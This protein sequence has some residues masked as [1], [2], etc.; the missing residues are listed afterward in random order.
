[1]RGIGHKV[2]TH[3]FEAHLARDIAHQQELLAIA[4]WDDL[5]GEVAVFAGSR[6]DDNGVRIVLHSEVAGELGLA[7][8]VLDPQPQVGGP[9]Q[10]EK[11]ASHPVEPDDLALSVQDDHAVGKR[12]G[13][14]LQLA[15]ELHEAL[16]VEALATMQTNDLRDDL[17]PD[18]AGVGRVRVATMPQPPLE[19]EEINE[20]QGEVNDESAGESGPRTAE[21][22]PDPEP[23]N[24]RSKQPPRSEPPRLC[25]RLHAKSDPPYA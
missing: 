21:H 17:A 7:Q 23:E 11:A 12:G 22:P 14:A 6:A 15:D 4:V 24:Y 18:T 16:L 19:A 13:R 2:P 25:S 3:G 20:L 8:E 10:V 1:M 5:Q 9:A